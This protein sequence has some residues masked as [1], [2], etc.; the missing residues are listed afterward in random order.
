MATTQQIEVISRRLQQLNFLSAFEGSN[1]ICK[2]LSEAILKTKSFLFFYSSLNNFFP[3]FV[4]SVNLFFR[5]YFSFLFSSFLFFFPLLFFILFFSPF[6]FCCY[7]ARKSQFAIDFF[8]SLNKNLC[9]IALFLPY[10]F[11]SIFFLYFY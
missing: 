10:N 1:W 4:G 9:R 7:F 3:F 11:S 6:F 2:L 5:S 8:R